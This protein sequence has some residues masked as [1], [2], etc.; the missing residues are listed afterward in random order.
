MPFLLP[1][2]SLYRHLNK[3][4]NTPTCAGGILLKTLKFFTALYEK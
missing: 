4:K 2:K 3:A 1:L